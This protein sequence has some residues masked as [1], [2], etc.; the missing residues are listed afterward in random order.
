MGYCDSSAPAGSHG[1]IRRAGRGACENHPASDYE[2]SKRSE[3]PVVSPIASPFVRAGFSRASSAVIAPRSDAP[4]ESIAGRKSGGS[5]DPPLQHRAFGAWLLILGV[6]FYRAV[7][8][9][10]LGGNCKFYPSCSHYAEQAIAIHGPRRGTWLALQRLLR[11][12]PFTRGG[13]DPFP[14]RDESES[15]AA[16]HGQESSR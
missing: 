15:R 3:S 13:F 9:P 7:H 6:H 14:D 10:F 5:I 4:A 16:L 12:R 11:C 2:M 1:G 8:S